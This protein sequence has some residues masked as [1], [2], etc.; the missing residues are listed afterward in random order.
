MEKAVLEKFIGDL[1]TAN[2]DHWNLR[3][4][5][6]NRTIGHDSQTCCLAL[7]DDYVLGIETNN[8][9]GS[10]TG[11]FNFKAIPYDNIDTASSY[12]VTTAEAVAFAK[13]TGIYS[14]EVEELIKAYGGKVTIHPGTGGYGEIKDSEGNVIIEP[15]LPGR[16][17]TG[18]T[19]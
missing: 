14:D 1:K 13:A 9:Y 12:N 3:F 5:G 11:S 10:T 6:G 7:L 2:I 4:E 17:T 19:V 18:T 15:G 8:N 16:V